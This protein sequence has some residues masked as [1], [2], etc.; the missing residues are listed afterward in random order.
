RAGGRGRAQGE[1]PAP[2]SRGGG[3]P[4]WR[5]GTGRLGYVAKMSPRLSETFILDEI[6]ALRRNGIP[7]KVYSLLPPVRDA[8]VHPE[9]QSLASEVEVLSPLVPRSSLLSW[10]EL[11]TCFRM[12]PIRTAYYVARVVATVH[13]RVKLRRLR[14]AVHL[15]CCLRR[16]RIAHVHAAWA[17]TPATVVRMACRIAGIP[18]SMSAHAKDIHLSDRDQLARKVAASR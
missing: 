8:L 11:A 15:A 6:L 7:V 3:A 9:A 2:G 13:P 17:H 1:R 5:G 16:D 18:W 12:R 14:E 4:S 10:R